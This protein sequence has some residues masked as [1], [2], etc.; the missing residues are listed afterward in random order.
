MNRKKYFCEGGET[1]L[2]L[3]TEQPQ[4]TTME[5][6]YQQSKAER[7]TSSGHYFSASER[8]PIIPH[9]FGKVFEDA[10]K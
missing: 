5:T 10:V 7:K 1:R 2:P 3:G 9:L 6:T 4:S 8:M